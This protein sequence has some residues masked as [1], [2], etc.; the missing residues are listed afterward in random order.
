MKRLSL[1]VLG[2]MLL[3]ATFTTP[4]AYDQATVAASASAFT[5][6]KGHWAEKTINEMVSRGILEGYPDGTFKPDATIKVDQFVKMLVLSY[7]DLHKMARAAG[8][9][10]F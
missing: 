8:M 1:L 5:D 10:H 4:I 3:W 2:I 6:T 7:T 9:L